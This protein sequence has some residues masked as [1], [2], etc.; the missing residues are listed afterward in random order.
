MPRRVDPEVIEAVFAADGP[1]ARLLPGYKP[2]RAQV[3]MAL[4]VAQCLDTP[5]GR[6]VVEAGTG[7][8]KSL[9]YLVPALL[10]GRRVVVATGTRALQD[11]LVDKDAPI[12]RAAVEAVLKDGAPRTVLRLKGRS[13][14]LCLLRHEAFARQGTLGLGNAGDDVLVQIS[15]FAETTTTGDRAELDLPEHL[16]IWSEL[17]AGKDTCVGQSCPRYDDCWLMKARRQAEQAS[18]VVVNHHLLCADQR[19]R[20]ESGGFDEGE[21]GFGVLPP[22][23]ALVVDEA[24]ALPDVATDH[25]GVSLSSEDV[26]R[27]IADVQRA[28]E[29]CGAAEKQRLLFGARD[30]DVCSGPFWTAVVKPSSSSAAERESR[31]PRRAE[32]VV[33]GAFSER[34][35]FAPSDAV[36]ALADELGDALRSLGTALDGARAV[37]ADDPG[38]EAAMQRATLNGL[39]ERT[40]RLRAQLSYLAGPAAE[41]RS[42][43]CFVDKGLRSTALVTAPIDVRAPLSGT[44]FSGAMPVILT[45]AT[46]AI[47]D[48]VGPFIHKVGLDVDPAE[49]DREEADGDDIAG[50]DDLRIDDEPSPPPPVMTAVYPSP[51]DHAGR[52]ALYAPTTMPEP[53]QAGYTARFDEEV[54]FLLELSQGGA[55]VLFTSRRAMDDAVRRLRPGLEALGIPVLKQGERPKAALLD[56]LRREGRAAVFATS[57]FWEGVDVVGKALRVVIID[58]LPFKVPSDPLVRA[59]G[60]HARSLGKDPFADIAVPEAAL[61]LK[62]GAGRLLRSVDDAGVVAILDGRLRGRRYGATF[63]K[64][65]PPMTRLGSRKTVTQFWVRHVEPVLGIGPDRLN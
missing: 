8:G 23:D 59:R 50:D 18:I 61:A 36:R 49:H 40:G 65:L 43:V 27:L 34:A 46:L 28:A 53:E 1:L 3:E 56:E 5:A 10:S 32:V 29:A 20:L 39:V 47:G 35:T 19:L 4:Q 51:F 25:F 24:H 54:L 17:D 13:N 16:P 60:E 57:S 52:A 21:G 26:A 12:A 45:S 62:Q 55:L 7:T 63:L 14:Y 37:F 11:Q 58:R 9:A 64:A 30:V 15:R 22:M 31:P 33:D 48:D 42:S 38:V 2:R 44:L 6:L 41:D